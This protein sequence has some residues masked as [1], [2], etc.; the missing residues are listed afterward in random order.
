MQMFVRYDC[1]VSMK[2]RYWLANLISGG[3]LVRAEVYKSQYEV[4]YHLAIAAETRSRQRTS[5]LLKIAAMP[6]PKANATVRRMAA[7]AREALE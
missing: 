7:V 6:T 3:E 2:F 4:M 1:G 5:A